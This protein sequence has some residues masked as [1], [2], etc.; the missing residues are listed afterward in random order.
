MSCKPKIYRGPNYQTWGTCWRCVGQM[1][2]GQ[3]STPA[4]AYEDWFWQ[5]MLLRN[6]QMNA[7]PAGACNQ[8][9]PQPEKQSFWSRVFG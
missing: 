7:Y 2:N 5:L 1:C 6:N 3:G 8:Q 9:A 4:Q